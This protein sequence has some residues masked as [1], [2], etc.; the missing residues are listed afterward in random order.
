MTDF[1]PN[2][3][4]RQSRRA[5][6]SITNSASTTGEIDFSG[7]AG[8]IVFVPSGSELTSLT[9]HAAPALGG[10]Y[11][12]LSD[13]AG[14]AVTQTVEAGKAYDLPAACYGAAALKIVGNTAGNVDVSLKG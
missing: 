2:R 14:E 8:G 10:T 9:Y 4:A 5:T 3:I 11:L 12:P 6:V 13:A 7:A 1:A